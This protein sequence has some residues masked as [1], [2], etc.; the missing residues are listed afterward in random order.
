MNQAATLVR[1]WVIVLLLGTMVIGEAPAPSFAT[2][3]E[4]E[5]AVQQLELFRYRNR[6]QQASVD[7][8]T[9][10]R[11]HSKLEPG[12]GAL[13]YF[14]APFDQCAPCKLL[15]D[16]TF[17]NARVIERMNQMY[18]VK[19]GVEEAARYGIDQFPVFAMFDSQHKIL[20]AQIAPT[21]PQELL[22]L[23]TP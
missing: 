5:L 12:Q 9:E 15:D 22:E 1:G 13:V 19:W 8:D 21:D 7:I 11:W 17:K 3:E 14:G 2:P 18:C 4:Q 20:G 16:V 23:L 6:T 10:I